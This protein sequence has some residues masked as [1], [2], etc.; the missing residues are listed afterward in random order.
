MTGHNHG[1]RVQ[2]CPECDQ[3]I[4]AL[5]PVLIKTLTDRGGQY[6]EYTHMASTAQRI[7]TA[8]RSGENWSSMPDHEKESLDSIAVKIA[9]LVC[10]ARMQWDSWHDIGGYAK[11]SEDRCPPP[12]KDATP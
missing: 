2:G 12:P 7:K 3:E 10:G 6:G 8:I 9:R 5:T 11:L 1:K 4:A